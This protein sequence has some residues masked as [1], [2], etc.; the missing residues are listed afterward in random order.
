MKLQARSLTLLS[1]IFLFHSAFAG[2]ITQSGSEEKTATDIFVTETAYVFESDLNHGGNFGKQDALQNQFEYG[3]RFALSGN[4]YIHAGLLYE[5]FDFGNTDA[6]VPVHLQKMAGVVGLDYMKGNDLGAFLQFRPGFYTEE[7]LGLASFDCPIL[8]GR[9]WI[10]QP[11]KLYLLTGAYASFLR[12]GFPVLP[13]VGLVWKPNDH[14]RLMGIVPEP[15]V[16]YTVNKQLEV[17]AGGELAGGSFRTDHHDE[18]DNI[19]HVDKLSGTQVDYSD[20]RA[21][22][23]LTYAISNQIDVD[24]GGGYSIRRSFDFNRA[25]ENYHTDP[26]PY[27]RLEFKAK[28]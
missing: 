11:D 26:A 8:L 13:L 24:L 9:F 20:Y 15:R 7:H 6:P 2:T 28:F 25:G 21:G 23:G 10:L 4:W 17:W 12:G 14:F 1:P 16:I 22:V 3:H 27:L 19:R 5:R 18:F